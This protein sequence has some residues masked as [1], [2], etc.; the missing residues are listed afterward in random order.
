MSHTPAEVREMG[1]Q[2]G[3]ILHRKTRRAF[4]HPYWKRGYYGVTIHLSEELGGYWGNEPLLSKVVG[5]ADAPA[6]L[7][8]LKLGPQADGTWCFEVTNPDY[9][10]IEQTDVGRLV[11]SSILSIGSHKKEEGVRVVSYVIMPTHIHLTLAF[12]DDLPWHA[13]RGKM[14]RIT[15][16]DVIR[17]LEQGTTS[18]YRRWLAGESVEEILAQPDSWRERMKLREQ[19]EHEETASTGGEETKRPFNVEGSLNVDESET[20][21]AAQRAAKL[22]S[23]PQRYAPNHLWN[24]Q[25]FNDSILL[26]ERRYYHWLLYVLQNP[27]HWKVRDQYPMLYEH[28]LHITLVGID[29]SSYGGLFLLRRLPRVQVFCHRA[30]RKGMLTS[31]ECKLIGENIST[32]RITVQAYEQRARELKLGRISWDWVTSTSPNCI[33]PIPYVETIAFQQEK[34][35]CLKACEE[36]AVLISPAISPGEQEIFYAALEEGYDCIKLQDKALLKNEHPSERDRQY[37]ATGQLLVLGPWEHN[38]KTRYATFHNLNN[39]ATMLCDEG[40]DFTIDRQTLEECR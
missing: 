1:L 8:G 35:R 2:V 5:D 26:T 37:C 40:I 33:L 23:A 27:Y 25:G 18:K 12:V 34:A 24:S 6:R 16:S 10:H 4:W 19:G 30:A 21:T 9:P 17:G 3:Q 15:L 20:K 13:F 31:E 32:G 14:V 7:D 38:E 11:E 28:R 39:L 36:G 22:P 29:F